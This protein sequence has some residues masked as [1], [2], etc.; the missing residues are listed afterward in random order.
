M[1]KTR[2]KFIFLIIPLFLI[3]FTFIYFFIMSS[4]ILVPWKLLG[5]PTENIFKIDGYNPGA[6]KLFVSTDSG[7]RYSLQYF[8]G[9]SFES[10][11]WNKDKN[12]Q[13]ELDPALGSSHT[14]E[15]ALS[16]PTP[17]Q[18]K[19]IYQFSLPQIEG[20]NVHKFALSEDGNLWYWGVGGS[21]FQGLLF[22]L[23]VTI[24]I[25]AYAFELFV[26]LIIFLTKRIKNKTM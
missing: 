4:G 14:S 16:P 6:G 3:L 21:V 20:S 26:F 2:T 19:Q 25:L 5:K 24:E 11:I 1:M 12:Y 23:I 7:E 22:V 10:P 18:V 13:V 17:F 8:P 9:D 15:G